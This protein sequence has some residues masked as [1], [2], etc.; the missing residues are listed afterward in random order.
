[1]IVLKKEMYNKKSSQQLVQT[2]VFFLV[3]KVHTLNYIKGKQGFGKRNEFIS[4]RL[5]YKCF[6]G[7]ISLY[8]SIIKWLCIYDIIGIA[9]FVNIQIA[10]KMSY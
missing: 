8:I 5:L 4:N 6:V 10:I 9:N 3:P 1:M 7:N 2:I